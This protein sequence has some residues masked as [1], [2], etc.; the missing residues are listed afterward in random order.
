ML[1]VR[2]GASPLHPTPPTAARLKQALAAREAGGS[3]KTELNLTK[4]T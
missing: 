3:H 1:P 4:E 2:S